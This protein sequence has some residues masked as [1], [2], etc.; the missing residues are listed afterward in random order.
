MNENK[1]DVSEIIKSDIHSNDVVLFM[2]G[3][4]DFPMCGFQPQLLKF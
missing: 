2:K 1:I 4:P 3:S